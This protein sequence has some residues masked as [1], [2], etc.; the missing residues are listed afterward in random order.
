VVILESIGRIIPQNAGGN[1]WLGWTAGFTRVGIL[2]TD[3]TQYRRSWPSPTG[4]EGLK[5]RKASYLNG[6]VCSLATLF[7]YFRGLGFSI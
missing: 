2:L 3:V 4:D 6:N 1:V 7:S 5:L